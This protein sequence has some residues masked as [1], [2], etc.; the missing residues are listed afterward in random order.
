VILLQTSL[1][2]HSVIV[3]IAARR[4]IAFYAFSL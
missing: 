3:R 4:A 2:V 1:E